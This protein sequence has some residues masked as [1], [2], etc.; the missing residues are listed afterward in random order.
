MPPCP[1]WPAFFGSHATSTD[2]R[3][4]AA[5]AD[6]PFE[7]RVQEVGRAF[8]DEAR[9]HKL[10]LLSARFWNDKL[11]DWAM[12]DEAFKVQLFRFVDA[13][14][15]LTS[16]E[17]VYEHLTDYLSQPGVKPPPGLS[18]GLKAG[19]VMKGTVAKTMAAQI[20]GMAEKFI[21]GQ[22]AES[23]VPKLRKLW[24]DGLAFSVDLLGEAC[25]SDREADEYQRKYLDLV[26]NLPKW[27]DDFPANE[28][29]ESD[30]L[31]RVPR[32]N[33]SIKVSSLSPRTDPIAFER[34]HRRQH[35]ADRA[36]PRSGQ[37]QRRVH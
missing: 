35:G 5:N 13:F 6:D 22:D 18:L 14:P 31:G 37:T 26:E 32:T 24:N 2:G 10:G 27:V 16:P 29:M 34:V 33:V 9:G 7:R 28:R 1:C 36:D 12:S 8:L 19:G 20:T 30:H 17:S 25:I 21:A 3:Q 15:T 11:M 4:A 23:A